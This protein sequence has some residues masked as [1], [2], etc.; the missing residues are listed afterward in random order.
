MKRW[1]SLSLACTVSVA[2]Y[3]LYLAQPS[4]LPTLNFPR[5]NA[6]Q[7]SLLT[8]CSCS[9][10]AWKLNF[11]LLSC[12]P[13]SF[14]IRLKFV[15]CLVFQPLVPTTWP[16]SSD[17]NLVISSI[18]SSRMGKYVTGPWRLSWV[19]IDRTAGDVLWKDVE[20]E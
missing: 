20:S 9:S 15:L 6:N 4:P 10:F 17:S 8:D 14:T 1:P 18:C 13:L 12:H 5:S 7:H 16:M 3:L 11:E 19:S 2:S